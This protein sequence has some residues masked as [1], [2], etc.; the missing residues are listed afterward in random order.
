MMMMMMM[1]MID[2]FG[3][4]S[5]Q[6]IDYTGADRPTCGVLL[7]NL[8]TYLFTLTNRK[9]TKDIKTNPNTNKLVRVEI[10]SQKNKQKSEDN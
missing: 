7:N 6:A 3:D 4:E 2:H 9:Y 10:K 5:F 1:M 8:F